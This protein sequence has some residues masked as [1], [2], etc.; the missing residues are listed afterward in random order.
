MCERREAVER[1]TSAG[2]AGPVVLPWGYLTPS[3]IFD[4]VPVFI[5]DQGVS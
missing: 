4:D 2:L 1:I 5:G 3:R